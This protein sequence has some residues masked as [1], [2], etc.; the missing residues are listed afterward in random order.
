MLDGGLKYVREANLAYKHRLYKSAKRQAD[1]AVRRQ[2]AQMQKKAKALREKAEKLIEEALELE[3][4]SY[5][6]NV[7][8]LTRREP[9]K[10]KHAEMVDEGFWA[11]REEIGVLPRNEDGSYVDPSP[12]WIITKDGV[13]IGRVRE[14]D[15]SDAILAV[16]RQQDGGYD[17]DCKYDA[18]KA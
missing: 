11:A 18:V 8:M 14:E 17:C 15:R 6:D 12:E 7:D 13:E 3:R 10:S 2:A 1:T 16:A 5:T 4:H 9:F